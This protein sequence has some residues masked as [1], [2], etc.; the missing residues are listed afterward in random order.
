MI[1]SRLLVSDDHL[2]DID[3]R[4]VLDHCQRGREKKALASMK[5]IAARLAVLEPDSEE[6]AALLSQAD[7]L[8]TRKSR[9]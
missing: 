9:L 7:A 6:Y 4:V 2:A 1:L 8:R 3:W 5:D